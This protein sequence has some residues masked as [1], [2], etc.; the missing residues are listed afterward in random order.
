MN[1]IL[2]I[3]L[4]GYAL[5]I[6]DD[7]YEYLT[8]YLESIRK[9]FSESEGR[10]EI[11]GDIEARL[12]EL[13]SQEMGTRTIV[14]LPDQLFYNTGIYTYVWLLTNNKPK[15]RK[16]KV[17]II[18]ARNQHADQVPSLGQKRHQLKDEHRQ[19][20]EQK[21]LAWKEDEDCKIFHYR[22]FCYL[23]KF[24]FTIKHLI[25]YSK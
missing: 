24:T 20:I 14:M 12:G 5:T 7:A 2:N 23:D 21:H 17:L 4:G 10:D 25:I 11:I 22:D 6:D 19:W 13:I 3:N 1:K 16:E 15:D 9:R 18:N 8:A